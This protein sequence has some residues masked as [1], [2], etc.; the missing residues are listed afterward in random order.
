M[1][2]SCLSQAPILRCQSLTRLESGVL[3][4]PPAIEVAFCLVVVVVNSGFDRC[5]RSYS[6]FIN[7]GSMRIVTSDTLTIKSR[8]CPA[9]GRTVLQFDH[10][11]FGLVQR[12][13]TFLK[14]AVDAA[15]RLRARNPF[16]SLACRSNALPQ[17]C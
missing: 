9:D 3:L 4:V 13:S 17:F 11:L 7:P 16:C 10:G 15:R 12:L 6:P 8:H 5:V 14:L 2:A 1:G